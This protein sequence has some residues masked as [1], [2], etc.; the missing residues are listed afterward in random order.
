MKHYIFALGLFAAAS[1]PVACMHTAAGTTD[2]SVPPSSRMT[3]QNVNQDMPTPN[4][5]T[6]TM[7]DPTVVDPEGDLAPPTI[8][9]KGEVEMRQ[10][11][12]IVCTPAGQKS[13][14]SNMTGR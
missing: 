14:D 11:G 13:P 9:K 2:N 5:N 12:K 8:C 7:S 6:T 3:D 10:S 4:H 1:L